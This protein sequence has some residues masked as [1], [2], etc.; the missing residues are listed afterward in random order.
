MSAKDKPH[1]KSC[2]DDYR[3]GFDRIFRQKEWSEAMDK[4]IEETKPQEPIKQTEGEK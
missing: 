3:N 4:V 1:S 2:T